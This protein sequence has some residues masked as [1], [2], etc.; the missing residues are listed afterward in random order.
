M[1]KVIKTVNIKNNNYFLGVIK[2]DIKEFDYQLGNGIDTREPMSYQFSKTKFQQA[3]KEFGVKLFRV[4]ILRIYQDFRR[5]YR[6][7]NKILTPEVVASAECYNNTYPQLI[8][9]VYVYD[10]DGKYVKKINVVDSD[11]VLNGLKIGKYYMCPYKEEERGFSKAKKMFIQNRPVYKY[12]INGNF[13]CRY[14]TQTL[15]EQANKYSNITKSIK[16]KQA[17]KNGFFWS[18]QPLPYV[19]WKDRKWVQVYDEQGNYIRG[20]KFVK[21]CYRDVGI[22][23]REYFNKDTD[24]NGLFYKYA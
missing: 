23:V 16:L 10:E 11:L 24:F 7:L 12:D 22:Y 14:E 18:M 15:A 9:D 21:Q 17:C 19:K 13:I 2:S 1:Y 5:A 20:Y 3:V 6:Y 8:E 4:E